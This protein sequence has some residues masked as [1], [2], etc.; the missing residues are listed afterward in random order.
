[1]SKQENVEIGQALFER[2]ERVSGWREHKVVGIGRKWIALD[3]GSRC[4]ID[5]L[6]LDRGGYSPR[7]LYTDPAIY[8]DESRLAAAWIDFQ[9]DVGRLHS[10]PKHMTAEAMNDIRR[11]LGLEVIGE[12]K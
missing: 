7:Q 1:M 4:T 9:R 3:T 6:K 5:T 8:E 10:R 12:S 2:R 11:T